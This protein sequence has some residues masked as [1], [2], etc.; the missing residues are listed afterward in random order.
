MYFVS[1]KKVNLLLQIKL[2]RVN[3]QTEAEPL[4]YYPN[5]P[6]SLKTGFQEEHY[7]IFHET[8]L[9]KNNTLTSQT[10]KLRWQYFSLNFSNTYP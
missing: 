4:H 1:E 3:N 10:L 5:I 6:H 8:L 2:N 9:I 7:Q